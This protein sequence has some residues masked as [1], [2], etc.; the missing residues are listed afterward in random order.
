MDV[1]DDTLGGSFVSAPLPPETDAAAIPALWLS[2]KE[3]AEFQQ[4]TSP[5]NLGFMLGTYSLPFFLL[6]AL[7]ILIT[8]SMDTSGMKT[9][10]KTLWHNKCARFFVWH[11]SSSRYCSPDGAILS[12]AL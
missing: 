10:D 6:H 7:S 8:G 11:L 12:D 3:E 9:K 2:A 1:I 5:W 4:W